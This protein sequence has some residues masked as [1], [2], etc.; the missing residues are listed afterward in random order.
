MT[1]AGGKQRLLPRLKTAGVRFRISD[2]Q[3][4]TG[5]SVVGDDDLYVNQNAACKDTAV[6][7]AAGAT[8]D[9]LQP[10]D[11]LSAHQK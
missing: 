6:C 4:W 3:I 11:R 9:N 5:I 8:V 10:N 2:G 7:I 1:L